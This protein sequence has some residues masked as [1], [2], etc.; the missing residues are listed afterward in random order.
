MIVHVV[1]MYRLRTELRTLEQKHGI[2]RGAG[3]GDGHPPRLRGHTLCLQLL[4]TPLYAITPLYA[5][6]PFYAVTPSVS[7]CCQQLLS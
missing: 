3:A 7:T 6:T 4:T 5:T 1:Y 2:L